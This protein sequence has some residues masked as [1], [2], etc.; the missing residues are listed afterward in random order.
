M[1][2]A[3]MAGC[4]PT[5]PPDTPTPPTSTAEGPTPA[6]TSTG[7]GPAP[8]PTGAEPKPATPPSPHGGAA[9]VPITPTKLLPKAQKLGIDFKKAPKL[10]QL[11]MGVKK[12]L[13]PL[14]KDALGMKDC[15][16]CHVEGDF[17]KET[18][19]IQ[20]ARGMWDNY[21][22][23]LRDNDGNALF[24][25]SC[26]DGKEDLIPRSD[27]DAVQKMMTEEYEGKLTRADG[28]EH[29]CSTCH[30][31]VFEAKIFESLWKVSAK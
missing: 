30:T 31:D 25:D 22:V 27:K 20:I 7:E 15:N 29:S 1:S 2:A 12:K 14:F 4:G 26:H 10:S 13:M 11:P 9:G 17:K 18:R 6:P 19:N 21:V 3:L 5:P 24:C 16:G 28:E 23:G 8:A